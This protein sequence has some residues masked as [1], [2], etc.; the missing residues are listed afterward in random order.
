MTTNEYIRGVKQLG[1]EQFKGK[2]WQR[3]YWDDII[4]DNESL[5]RIAHNIKQNPTRWEEDHLNTGHWKKEISN[6][7]EGQVLT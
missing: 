3:N 7:G 2:L 6:M 1:W 5:Y 4:R